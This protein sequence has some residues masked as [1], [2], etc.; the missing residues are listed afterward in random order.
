MTRHPSWEAKPASIRFALAAQS[1]AREVQQPAFLV[2]DALQRFPADRQIAA[3][4]AAAVILA[5]SIGL[6]P[7]DLV[8]RAKR[9]VRDAL[10]VE[11]AMSAISDYAK[12]ELR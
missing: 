10:A 7:H 2:I 6:D 3:A 9:Q 12:G 11:S 5:N 4:F 1:V 8:T